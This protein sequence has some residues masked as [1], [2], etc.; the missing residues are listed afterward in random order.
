MSKKNKRVS[1]AVQRKTELF[2]VVFRFANYLLLILV[3]LID[4]IQKDWQP[5][6]YFYIVLLGVIVGV[7]TKGLIDKVGK[8]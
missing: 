3:M 6:E 8:K 5:P 2:S 1:S 4:A 7:D